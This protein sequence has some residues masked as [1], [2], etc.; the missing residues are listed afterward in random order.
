MS[1]QEIK[2]PD[3]EIGEEA[4][5]V[6][7][8]EPIELILNKKTGEI[9]FKS[10]DGQVVTAKATVIDEDESEDEEAVV[11]RHPLT[12][13][14]F[15][16]ALQRLHDIG[17]TWTA[18]QNIK[19]IG[20]DDRALLSAEFQQFQKDYPTLPREVN[21][22]AFHQLIGIDC[23]ADVV[24]DEETYRKKVDVAKEFYLNDEYRE[25][26]FFKHA[27]KVPYF[28]EIDWEIVIKIYEKNVGGFPNIPYALLTLHLNGPNRKVPNQ[29]ITVAVNTAM[30]DGL[31]HTLGKIKEALESSRTFTRT[32]RDLKE[33][34]D[35][36]KVQDATPNDSE[37]RVG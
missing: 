10:K 26:F 5:S 34:A 36:E 22:I 19:P 14:Q 13:E 21:I 37:A 17:L 24:G 16:E 1:E 7:Q 20:N 28:S 27:I 18:D 12:P 8:P 35:L 9:V 3:N 33:K 25:A 2:T 6:P 31:M 15:R 23:P 4:L 32:L 11:E 30:L 29:L